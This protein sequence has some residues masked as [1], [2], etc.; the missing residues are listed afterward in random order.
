MGE[1]AAAV[2]SR[3][4]AVVLKGGGAE[5]WGKKSISRRRTKDGSRGT[6]ARRC[7]KAVWWVAQ[8]GA[9]DGGWMAQ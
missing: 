1:G 5:A 6:L 3:G 9:G 2:L 7:S 8:C 4:A